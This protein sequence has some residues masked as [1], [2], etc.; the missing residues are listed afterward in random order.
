M[1]HRRNSL[2]LPPSL[3][4]HMSFTS[5]SLSSSSSPLL[6]TSS[7]I[8]H[9]P[10]SSCSVLTSTYGSSSVYRELYSSLVTY[11]S[12]H[13][14]LTTTI[15]INPFYLR[16]SNS[17]REPSFIIR[18]LNFKA[19]ALFQHKATSRNSF[20]PPSWI[21]LLL[22]LPSASFPP[23]LPFLHYPD[24]PSST[25]PPLPPELPF[26]QFPSSPQRSS[27]LLSTMDRASL[28]IS[29]PVPPSYFIPGSTSY[30]S[31]SCL[32]AAIS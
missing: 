8:F 9:L 3:P 22:S 29:A 5:Y 17:L 10:L 32:L 1:I 2:L 13:G 14:I 15:S 21:S 19:C 16:H 11:S 30:P 18:P 7:L 25:P 24:K 6:L 4:S 27:D 26:Q 28:T 31:A 20:L 23:F 12:H